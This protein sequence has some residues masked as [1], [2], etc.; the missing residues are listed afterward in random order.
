MLSGE[1]DR[2]IEYLSKVIAIRTEGPHFWDYAN[3]GSAFLE[4]GNLQEAFKDFRT[5]LELQPGKPCSPLQPGHSVGT[6]R[7]IH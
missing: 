3:R 2:A 4:T 1:Y 6:K 5:A 7:R